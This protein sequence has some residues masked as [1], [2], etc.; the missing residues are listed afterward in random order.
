MSIVLIDDKSLPPAPY[1]GL[2]PPDDMATRNRKKFVYGFPLPSEWFDFRF[3]HDLHISTFDAEDKAEAQRFYR[4]TLVSHLIGL[5][6]RMEGWVCKCRPA[7][8]QTSTASS[9]WFLVIGIP[10]RKPSV[11]SVKKLR[12]TLILYGVMEIPRWYPKH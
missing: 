11:E 8:V 10:G 3:F 2:C 9:C 6:D 4:A 1:V 7:S 12:E 5:C